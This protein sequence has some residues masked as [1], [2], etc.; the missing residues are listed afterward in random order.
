[1]FLSLC[2]CVCVCVRAFVL[3]FTIHSGAEG[4]TIIKI[5]GMHHFMGKV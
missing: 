5:S 4:I 1:M 2:V 3:G